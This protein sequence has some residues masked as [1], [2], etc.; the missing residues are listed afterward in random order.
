[1]K[2]IYDRITVFVHLPGFMKNSGLYAQELSSCFFN[3]MVGNS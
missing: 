1:M 2:P 3:T